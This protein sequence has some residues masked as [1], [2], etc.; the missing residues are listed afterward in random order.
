MKFSI[1][2][3]MA[4]LAVCAAARAT[5]VFISTG[6]TGAQVQCDIAHTQ[7]WTY[8]VSENVPD[9]GGALLDMKRGP[10]MDPNFPI[11]FDII[12]GTFDDFGTA[13]P[14]LS[15]TLTPGAFAQ[16]WNMVAFSNGTITL[17]AGTTYTGVL[18]SNAE[19]HQSTAYF[20]KGG[21][22]QFVDAAGEPVSGGGT[23][24]SGESSAPV[25]EPLT[26]A[27]VGMGIAGLGGYIRRRHVVTK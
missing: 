13:T 10:H 19:D 15:V 22:F 6:H 20:I 18:H 25:P 24:V 7:Y 12:Q 1:L 23:I 14:L 17:N 5:T 26:L 8:S 11:T 27:A 9:V 3:V 21:N 4:V 16:D 2:G